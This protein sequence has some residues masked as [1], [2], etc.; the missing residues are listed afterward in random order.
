LYWCKCQRL[1]IYHLFS[2]I[3]WFLI[4]QLHGKF[5]YFNQVTFLEKKMIQFEFFTLLMIKKFMI[6]GNSLTYHETQ[7]MYFKVNFPKY[8]EMGC[9]LGN[10]ETNCLLHSL[11]GCHFYQTH[12]PLKQISTL[13]MFWWWIHGCLHWQGHNS[14]LESSYIILYLWHVS[15]CVYLAL[16]KLLGQAQNHY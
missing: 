3:L 2:C 16:F 1:G 8:L 5:V 10:K 14:F 13:Q 9:F 15:C 4:S 6:F 7:G 11:E 12:P